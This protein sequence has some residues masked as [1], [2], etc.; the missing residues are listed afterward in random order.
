MEKYNEVPSRPYT[1]RGALAFNQRTVSGAMASLLGEETSPER[2]SISLGELTNVLLLLESMAMSSRMCLDGTLPPADLKEIA[3]VLGRVHERSG[4]DLDIEFLKPSADKLISMFKS[5]ADAA[6]LLIQQSLE[7][8]DEQSDAPLK[9]DVSKFLEE[10]KSASQSA[11]PNEIAERIAESAATGIETFR[12]SKC[13]AGLILAE[14]DPVPLLALAEKTI[15]GVP[16]EKQRKAIAIL[17]NRFRINYVNSLAA[18]REA[19]YLADGAIEDLKAAQVVLF[20]RYLAK[21]IAER[22]ASELSAATQELFDRSLHGVPLGFA[23]LMNSRGK[24]AVDLVEEAMRIRDAKFAFAA[25]RETP[26]TRFVHQFNED[27]FSDFRDYLFK[28][29][30]AD[31]ITASERAEIVTNPWRTIRIP[32]A[33]GGAAAI[34]AGALLGPFGAAAGGLLIG[35]AVARVERLVNEEPGGVHV[36]QYRKFDRYFARATRNDRLAKA[37]SERVTTLFG[38][39]LDPGGA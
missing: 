20:S 33:A 27:E 14:Q 36:D 34:A 32:G 1:F 18:L 23:I 16:E 28:A 3:A 38:R 2:K 17:I 10:L 35:L 30:W 21:K 29:R 37:L 8:L 15:A 5:A 4:V 7:R 12:G 26:Q 13:L 22:H 31:L 24:S 19:A 6:A 39:S 25:A 9:G 11:A